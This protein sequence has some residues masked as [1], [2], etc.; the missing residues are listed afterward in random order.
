MLIQNVDIQEGIKD[1]GKLQA[2]AD[3]S[4]QAQRLQKIIMLTT[5]RLNEALYEYR[6]LVYGTSNNFKR[7][8]G[9]RHQNLRDIM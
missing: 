1:P 7:I 4:L 3:V 2:R 6:K 5:K 8:R 9:G